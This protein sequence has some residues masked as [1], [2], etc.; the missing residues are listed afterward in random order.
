M[1]SEKIH[2]DNRAFKFRNDPNT[3]LNFEPVI[4]DNVFTPE[5]IEQIYS[6]AD[7]NFANIEREFGRKAYPIFQEKAEN[8]FDRVNTHLSEVFGQ[9]MQCLEDPFLIRYNIEYGFKPKLAPHF[10]RRGTH[11]AVLD[12]QLNANEDW[13]VVI[14]GKNYNLKFNQGLV[15]MGTDQVHWREP[16]ELKA[17]TEIDM[18][19]WNVDFAPKIEMKEEHK[20]AMLMKELDLLEQIGMH[21]HSE[22][23]DDLLYNADKN[24]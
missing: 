7:E 2:R 3:R 22:K 13:A 24:D 10:D 11:K 14:D 21:P 23:I 16:K 15:F 17:G 5:E 19:I 20:Q 4:I 9:R 6:L 8:I 18:I 12:V 1:N